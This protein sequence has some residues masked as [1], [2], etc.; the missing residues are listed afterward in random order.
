M[1]KGIGEMNFDQRIFCGSL[2][3][4]HTGQHVLLAGWM[5]DNSCSPQA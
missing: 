2:N 3:T 5:D 4:D 1:R